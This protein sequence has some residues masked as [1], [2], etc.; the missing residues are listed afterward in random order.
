MS[1]QELLSSLRQEADDKA[2]KF[3][4]EAKS[5]AEQAR[6][7]AS[8][9]LDRI[10]AEHLRL[11]ASAVRD[12]TR[13]VLSAAEKNVRSMRLAAFSG[14]SERL[15]HHAACKLPQLRDQQYGELFDALVRELPPYAWETVRVNPEDTA[16]AQRYF[17]EAKVVPD[18]LIS[19]GMEVNGGNGRIR[20][21]NTFE[22]RLER[23]WPELLPD[24]IDMVSREIERN[25]IARD[26]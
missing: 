11:Q 17:P 3:W 2:E 21:V 12:A 16:L 26:R 13:H 4:R 22:K 7:E 8:A 10:Q 9:E 19:G 14:L 23:G 15:S 18:S 25:A 6:N 24:L 1:Y 5:G 20:I